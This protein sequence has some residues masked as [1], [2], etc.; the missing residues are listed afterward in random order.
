M[1]LHALPRL[2]CALLLSAHANA[3][4]A[5]QEAP[6]DWE[7]AGYEP[8]AERIEGYRELLGEQRPQ[9]LSG[10]ELRRVTTA[11]PWPR[12]LVVQDGALYVLARGRHRNAGG[13]D[14]SIED[15]CGALFSVDPSVSEV[16]Q[17]G[18]PAGE[19]V[20][21]NA[22]VFAAPSGPPFLLYDAAAGPPVLDGRMDRPYCT[23]AF[24]EASSNFFI[25]GFSGADL[26][27]RKFRKNASDSIHRFDLRDGRW[28]T[29]ELH[30]AEVVPFDRDRY[31]VANAY[32]P[33]HDPVENAAP[34][35]WLNGPNGA[36]V[37]GDFLYAVGKDNHVVAQYDMEGI[38]EDPG[39]PGP[40]SRPVL[41]EWVQLRE[42]D[43][44]GGGTR[45]LRAMGPSALEARDGW[46]YVGYRTSSV[47]LRFPIDERGA[48][49]PSAPGELIAVFEAWEPESG[50]SADLIDLAFNSGGE[51]FAACAE[52]G[53][54]WNLGVPDPEH[55]FDGDDQRE[56]GAANRPWA[57]L[58]ELTDNPR[59]RCGNIAFDEQ[60]RL[61]LCS[62]NYDSGTK[63]AG[64][65]Y[66]VDP[67]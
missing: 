60:D 36:H 3:L 6:Q 46:L 5:R 59:A 52:S 12:G 20:R 13:I 42:P 39:A 17:S 10:V 37:V 35:G 2:G 62:G 34:H 38:R 63:L 47:V 26:P 7:H 45:T 50:R 64:V 58:R 33:H 23:L 16:V 54:I 11:V 44:A 30:N 8:R 31:V 61:Y 48:L 56:G 51:L 32:Y 15:H 19:D 24:D 25:C 28:H 9:A 4:T 27:G 40:P 53:R 43:W 41:G 18:V 22:R 29:V 21:S 55:P 67:R 66:R 14:P 65:I 1:R 49:D 57:D